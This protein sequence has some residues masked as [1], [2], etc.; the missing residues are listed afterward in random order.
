[1]SS[2][3]D[4]V[5]E[6]KDNDGK[7]KYSMESSYDEDEAI[8]NP[9]ILKDIFQFDLFDGDSI[10]KFD[11]FETEIAMSE[12]FPEYYK[13]YKNYPY[14]K[15]RILCPCTLGSYYENDL[16]DCLEKIYKSKDAARFS[17]IA[18]RIKNNV[19][20]YSCATTDSLNDKNIIHGKDDIC[21]YK[22]STAY[23]AYNFVKYNLIPNGIDYK[24]IFDEVDFIAYKNADGKFMHQY[25]ADNV[26]VSYNKDLCKVLK[27]LEK[28][29]EDYKTSINDENRLRKLL[30]EFLDEEDLEEKTP[31]SKKIKA[32]MEG[33]NLNYYT[34]EEIE[35]LTTRIEEMKLLIRLVGENGRV[36][37]KISC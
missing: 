15:E 2:Y 29:Y 24:N 21:Y 25:I 18:L 28:E 16:L 33:G 12:K 11:D 4:F 13:D 8:V 17:D 6:K 5:I 7:W 10:T 9:Y 20:W 32:F 3:L 26:K 23:E 36:V 27:N 22:F 35:D 30:N 19:N 37:W 34:Q 14:D 1:M 31:L